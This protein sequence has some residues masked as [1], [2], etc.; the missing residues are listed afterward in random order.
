MEWL[1]ASWVAWLQR[2]KNLVLS[3]G[4]LIPCHSVCPGPLLE[5]WDIISPK[6][7]IGSDVLLAEKRSSLTTAALPFTQ[8]IISQ[9]LSGSPRAQLLLEG[10]ASL[11]PPIPSLPVGTCPW[12][13]QLNSGLPPPLLLSQVGRTLSKVQ[14]VL[15]W[16]YGED[17][18]PFKPPLS[19]AEFHTYLNHEGQLSRPEELRL[20]IYHGGVEPSLR[21]VSL[22]HYTPIAPRIIDKKRD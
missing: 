18:K 5:D 22:P 10:S 2:K 7:V 3:S 15:S 19:D 12:P 8:S 6:D 14:Q 4:V 20:R 16:S 21:K 9:V 1:I 17:V 11:A 13:T